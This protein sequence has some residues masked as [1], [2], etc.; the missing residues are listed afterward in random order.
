MG[1]HPLFTAFSRH[2]LTPTENL[3]FPLTLCIPL[4]H[5]VICKKAT[6]GPNFALQKNNQSPFLPTSKWPAVHTAS[7]FLRS[8]HLPTLPS[9]SNLKRIT[10]LTLS[11]QFSWIFSL[12]K[13]RVTRSKNEPHILRPNGDVFSLTAFDR[14]RTMQIINSLKVKQAF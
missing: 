6:R 2:H 12:L 9:F 4:L 11:Q 1:S 5:G 10:Y 14:E 7:L 3:P 8:T 13:K